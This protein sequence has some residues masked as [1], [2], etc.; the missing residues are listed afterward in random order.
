MTEIKRSDGKYLSSYSPKDAKFDLHRASAEQIARLYGLDG[1]SGVTGFLAGSKVIEFDRYRYRIQLCG[2]YLVFWITDDDC[3]LVYARFCKVP[4][5]PM[6]QWRRSLKWRAKF[7]VILPDIQRQYPSHK[8]LFLTLTIKTCQMSELRATIKHMGESFNRL[9]KLAFFPFTGCVKSLEVTRIWD[10]YDKHGNFIGRHG[11]K[12]WY[13]N[14]DPDK[15]YWTTKPT[16][17]VHPHL[18]ILGM[19]PAS[20]FSTGYTKQEDWRKAWGQSLKVEYLPHVNIQTVKNKKG[21]QILP[22]PEDVKDVPID[23]IDNSGM[24]KGLCETLKYTIKEQDLIGKFCTDENINSDW[25][26][27]ITEE[28]YKLRKVEYRG[29]LKQFGKD[30]EKSLEDLITINEDKDE[31]ATAKGQ[32]VRFWYSK[33]EERYVREE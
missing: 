25:L 27:G 9:S 7:L 26:K 1:H 33:L 17:E 31:L 21:Q 13:E 18:H 28:L 14:K 11:V 19:V 29:V 16:D 30:V 3:R 6:C 24:I 10:W 32:E 22:N 23:K 4:Y 2:S 12:W 8:W 15:K 20:Y 5:C